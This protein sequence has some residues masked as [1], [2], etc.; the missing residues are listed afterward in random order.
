MPSSMLADTAVSVPILF[1]STRPELTEHKAM[2]DLVDYEPSLQ[3]ASSFYESGKVVAAVC[4]GPAALA[5]VKLTDGSYLIA[6]QPITGFSN[7]EEEQAQLTEAM[8]FLLEDL[9]Q[10]NSNGKY[11]KSENPWA[12]LVSIGREGKLLTGQNPASA[13]PLGEAIA[14]ALGVG[15]A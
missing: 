7:A 5:K 2:F 11:Q 4:H 13:G 6:D 15:A 8:P 3:L 10:T 12:P 1:L 14:N 9:L